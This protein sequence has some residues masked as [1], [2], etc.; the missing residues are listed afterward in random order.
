V[1][2]LISAQAWAQSDAESSPADKFED[3]RNPKVFFRHLAE[4][5]ARLWTSPLRV[6]PQDAEW[7]VPI[8][9]ITT[10]LIMTDRTSGHEIFRQNH[11]NLSDHI[12]NYGLGAYGGVV[13]GLYF[14]GHR[15]GNLREQETALLA[16]ESGINALAMSTVLKYV[17]ERNRP[18][19]G[20]GKGHFFRPVSGSFYS[21]HA[22]I[23][24]SF[25]SVISSEYPG[26]LSRTLAYGGATAISFARVSGQKHWPSDVF[27][28]SVA[29]YLTGKNVFRAL[30]DPDVDRESY[31]VF[32]RPRVNWSV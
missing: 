20:D 21:T 30:H 26:W 16:G 6:K 29:G 32:I 10:G 23:A 14:F 15:S 18:L 25:A 8:A 5:Q 7:L 13:A 4:D 11:V 9:G 1:I 22:A 17:F 27:V 19:K 3:S 24:W 28:G 2:L 12:A 31:G